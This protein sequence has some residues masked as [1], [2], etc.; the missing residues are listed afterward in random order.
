MNDYYYLG[1][2]TKPFGYKGQVIIYLDTDEPERYAD[3]QAVFIAEGGEYIPYMIEEIQLRGDHTAIVK[4]ED[5]DGES[6]KSLLK[7]EL[8]LPMS[9][10]PPLTGNNFY[11]HEVIGFTII[12]KEKGDIGTCKDFLDV[13]G[14]SIMVIDHLGKEI[15]I[16]AVDD[17]FDEIDRANQKMHIHAPEGLIDIYLSNEHPDS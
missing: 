9:E 5:I 3:L 10:L 17:F 7:S 12:D 2:I 1:L 4:F 8:Y 16:P 15:L 6:A 13:N 11:Y 14:Q